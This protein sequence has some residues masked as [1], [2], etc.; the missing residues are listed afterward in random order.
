MHLGLFCFHFFKAAFMFFICFTMSFFFLHSYSYSLHAISVFYHSCTSLAISFSWRLNS[1]A[2]LLRSLPSLWLSLPLCF[3][4][5]PSNPVVRSCCIG[6]FYW[7]QPRLQNYLN[8]ARVNV[9][10]ENAWT[11]VNWH[12]IEWR[13]FSGDEK[14]RNAGNESYCEVIIAVGRGWRE[15][16]G[17]DWEERGNNMKWKEMKRKNMKGHHDECIRKKCNTKEWQ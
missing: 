3:A 13:D 9:I 5:M 1:F 12:D 16:V 6:V 8:N 15:T 10:G 17:I 7:N 2:F 11:D 4:N 14:R